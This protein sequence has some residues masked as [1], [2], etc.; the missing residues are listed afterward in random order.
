MP[1]VSVIIPTYNRSDVVVDSIS[2][3]L[4]QTDRDLEVIVVDDG[5]T[6]DTAAVV[7]SI[8]DERLKYFHKTN[9]GPAAA[10]NHGLAKA[11]GQYVAFLD[12]DD[13]WPEN[14]LEVM[15][16]ALEAHPEMGLAYS[17]ITIRCEDGREIRSYKLRQSRSGWV[18]KDLF[19]SGFVWTSASVIRRSVLEGF[20]YDEELR[21]SYEDGDFFLRLSL[22]T[23]FLFVPDVQAVKREHTDNL[24]VKV[25]IQ[26]T[27]ILVLERFYYQLAGKKHIGMIAARKRLSHA[28]RKVAEE[29]TRQ[30][31]KAAALSLYKRAISYWPLDLRLYVR[32]ARTLALSR[33]RD[34]EPNW[35]M[36]TLSNT[37]EYTNANGWH[38]KSFPNLL[39][40]LLYTK[41]LVPL[42]G[43]K[44]SALILD[45]FVGL[46]CKTNGQKH[47]VLLLR[48]DAIGDFIMWLDQAKEYRKLF[49][50]Q[51][52]TL[53]GNKRWANFAKQ[54]PYW[55]AVWSFDC[56]AFERDP[57]YRSNLI[58]RVKEANFK[59]AIQPTHVRFIHADM[60]VRAS[61]A[62]IK[63]GSTGDPKHK[64]KFQKRYCDRWYT[65]LVPAE[66][67]K[68]MMLLREA[69]FIRNLGLVDFKAGIPDIAKFIH[70]SSGI[71][72]T[73]RA[74]YVICPGSGMKHKCWPTSKFAELAERIYGATSLM[75]VICGSGADTDMAKT[76][77]KLA[78]IHIVDLTG[79]TS[80]NDFAWIVHNAEFSV[81]NDSGSVH[82][83]A[84]V[85]THSVCVLGGGE[86]GRCLPYI[87][88][89]GDDTY[90]PVV[91]M[92]KM[93]C[94]GCN[95]RKPCI[96]DHVEHKDI[97]VPCI[98]HVGVDEVFK[99]VMNIWAK[100][101]KCEGSL[102]E[103]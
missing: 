13:L 32:M 77:T 55:D 40:N 19:K 95:W 17:P 86:F 52:V 11:N 41:I 93:D 78:K 101:Q 6:D 15:L 57:S 33:E 81:C 10:R 51:R 94:F 90:C 1:K 76:I 98:E 23:Q 97:C 39:L 82:I 88:E 83:S 43:R 28:C 42:I 26:P 2:S 59:I 79:S 71:Q 102:E 73:P 75:T 80:L 84:A 46:G 20:G 63:I 92:H 34:P 4:A 12:H 54:L 5:S 100:L 29:K 50:E 18:T 85:K 48:M 72:S 9:G 91:C 64:R 22:R 47:G 65:K 69:E 27:R 37:G 56:E 21:Q 3:V 53:I 36:P 87:L 58:K 31:A 68:M 74:Y 44:F 62:Q 103:A 67:K 49:P 70:T 14:F 45:T 25:G 89:Q 38:K 60:I 96:S 30:K 24:S 16:K 66:D 35:Q 8:D 7:K 61:H 99:K